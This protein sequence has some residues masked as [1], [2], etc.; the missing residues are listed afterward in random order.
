[1]TTMEEPRR[2][3][4]LSHRV[5]HGAAGFNIGDLL[6]SQAMFCFAPQPIVAYAGGWGTGKSVALCARMAVLMAAIPNNRGFLGRLKASDLRKST[7]LVWEEVVPTTWIKSRNRQEGV[8]TLKNNSQVLF[9]HIDDPVQGRKHLASLNVAHIGIDQAEEI[10]DEDFLRLISRARYRQD[11]KHSIALAFNPAGHNWL[12]RRIY[13]DAKVK[14]GHPKEQLRDWDWL[15]VSKRSLGLAVPT[16][17]NTAE[18]GGYLPADYLELMASQYP[19]DWAA[20]YLWCSFEDFE[21]KVYPPYTHDSIHN[22]DSIELDSTW[23]FMVGIDVGGSAPWGLVRI[24]FDHLGRAIVYDELYRPNLEIREVAAWITADP[25]W[26]RAIGIIDYENRPVMTE[27]QQ[28]LQEF[29]LQPARKHKLANIARVNSYMQLNVKLPHI[30]SGL[31]LPKGTPRFYVTENCTHTRREHD[32]R[33]WKPSLHGESKPADDSDH[34]CDAVEYV[35]AAAEMEPALLP[36]PDKLDKLAAIDPASAAF[37][38]A[39]RKKDRKGKDRGELDEAVRDGEE[40]SR[41]LFD[42]DTV[43]DAFAQEWL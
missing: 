27:L 41:G 19:P 11:L 13:K 40:D 8:Y 29:P 34:T 12:W 22:I 25:H 30:K 42:D 17:E 35:L 26:R 7:Q 1:M 37:W 38:R 5:G 2:F 16:I 24:A 4:L 32:Q 20:R 14:R 18:L 23:R 10:T 21:G 3:P 39:I 9:G 31:M 33:L 36:R 43:E 28:V 15:Y 6:P